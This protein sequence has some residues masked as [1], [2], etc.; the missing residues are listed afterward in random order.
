MDRK[1]N[2]CLLEV[3]KQFE[4]V[5]LD[6]IEEKAFKVRYD[7]KYVF[8]DYEL[9]DILLML[10]KD[11]RIL[12]IN[13][14]RIF[15]YENL[16]F[17]TDSLYFYTQHHNGKGNRFKVRFR[18]YREN[19]VCYFEIKSKSNKY[20]ISKDRIRLEN[21]QDT[22]NGIAKDLVLDKTNINPESL[23]PKLQINY[24]RITLINNRMGEKIT[25]D[26]DL[27]FKNCIKEGTLSSIAI[28]E[29][30][31]NLLSDSMDF[32]YYMK[33]RNIHPFRVSKYCTGTIITNPE[34]KYNRFKS[35]MLF[36]NKLQRLANG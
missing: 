17:D 30:K 22:I 14:I 36:L 16:Y 28:A 15:S 1:N 20:S 13:G 3:I 10:N 8:P 35:K 29:V 21:F 11:Y 19:A 5:N 4:S 34:V 12:E 33:T 2:N 26:T 27:Y 25:F 6:T 32:I 31:N 18:R 9:S 7:T 23:H 24:R